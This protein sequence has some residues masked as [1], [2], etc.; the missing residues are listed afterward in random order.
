MPDHVE[1][2]YVR[3]LYTLQTQIVLNFLLFCNEFLTLLYPTSFLGDINPW[4]ASNILGYTRRTGGIYIVVGDTSTHA[5][6][7]IYGTFNGRTIWEH[8]S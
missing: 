8:T 1:R 7:L 2:I 5:N 3:A 6:N 4:Q